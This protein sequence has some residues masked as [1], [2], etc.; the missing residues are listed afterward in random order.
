MVD[1]AHSGLSN[2]N[3]VFLILF[4]LHILNFKHEDSNPD[5]PT[6]LYLRSGLCFTCQR[7]LNEKRRTQRKR[8]SDVQGKPN[9]GSAADNFAQKRVRINGEIVDVHADAI[10]LNGPFDGTKHHGPG[11]EY[12]QIVMDLQKIGAA[13]TQET[14]ELAN[15][16]SAI[17]GPPPHNSPEHVQIDALYN[18]TFHTISKGIFLLSELKTSFDAAVTASIAE[19]ATEEVLDSASIADVVASAAAVAAAQSA[20]VVVAAA[21]AGGGND[22][23]SSSMIPL[24]LAA[25]SKEGEPAVPAKNE[26]ENGPEVEV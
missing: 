25:E 24:L 18:K 21:A 7:L 10:I 15:T 20:E 14:A 26:N 16:M 1:N 9:S 11:Y 6:S 2:D 5:E 13:V 17:A 8:K 22:Q 19:K 12:P 23:A 4:H 3:N